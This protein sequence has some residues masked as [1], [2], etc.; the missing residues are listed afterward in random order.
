[1]ND[2]DIMDEKF[3]IITAE[4][5]QLILDEQ[6][7][8]SN[9]HILKI[10]TESRARILKL[11][12]SRNK[13]FFS[14]IESSDA[15]LRSH[16]DSKVHLIILYI[17]IAGS[18]HLSTVLPLNDLTTILQVFTQEM[19]I[20]IINNYGYVLKYV[21]DAIIAYF[22]VNDNFS[23]ASRNA[24]YCALNMLTIVEQAINPVLKEFDFPELHVKIGIDSGE[25]AIVE[26]A[27]SRKSSHIDIIGYPMNIAAKITSLAKPNHILIGNTTYSGLNPNLDHALRKLGLENSEYIDYQ[28]GD[29]YII[30]S[31][32]FR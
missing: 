14:N 8:I 26:Y 17:D 18:T 6:A 32:T 3:P 12:K 15:F 7:E 10:I 16:V 30:Y 27:F 13:H 2:N 25:N 1:M 11:L 20:V 4:I 29:A 22:P 19:T 21:G 23:L 31:F 24:I 28:T 5:T 9:A